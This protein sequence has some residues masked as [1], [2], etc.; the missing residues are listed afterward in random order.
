MIFY[1]IPAAAG[2]P[3]TLEATQDDARA[4]CRFRGLKPNAFEPHEV[5]TDK[6]GLMRYLNDMRL[7]RYVDALNAPK[8]LT[9]DEIRNSNSPE[10][11][12][13]ARRIASGESARPAPT[14]EAICLAIADMSGT[15]LGH[16][17]LEV[18][19]RYKA[20]ANE[21]MGRGQ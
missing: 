6:A 19:A 11:Q 13:A 5:P 7:A 20:L 17:A 9:H 1:L 8:P 16:V 2:Q 18:S 12:V 10:A 15:A 21:A 4:A 14:E 3:E